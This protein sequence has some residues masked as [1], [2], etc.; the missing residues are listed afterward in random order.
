MTI[1]PIRVQFKTACQILDI[2]R[3]S[4]RHLVRTDK[5]FPKVIKTGDTKQA[6]VYFDYAELVEWHNNQKQSLSILEA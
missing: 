1:K 6:P 3:E 2:S 5:T 4:L